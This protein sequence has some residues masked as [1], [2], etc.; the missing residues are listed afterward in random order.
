MN[1]ASR[2]GDHP[3]EKASRPKTIAGSDN[4]LPT[5]SLV[6]LLLLS[7]LVIVIYSNTFSASFHF[8][9]EQNIVTNPQ[10]KGLSNFLDFSASRYV[11]FLSFAL[12][13]H[14]GRLDVFG[15]HLVNLLIHITNGLLVYTLVL[16]VFK[17][18]LM[19]PSSAALLEPSAGGIAQPSAWI[20]FITALLFLVHPLQ[21]QAVTYIVQRFTSLAT[22]FYLLSI[23]CYLK[24]RLAGP[25]SKGRTAWYAGAFVSTLLAMKTKEISFTL[26][27]MILWVEAIFFWPLTRKQW[28]ALIPFLLTLPIIPLSSLATLGE[29]EGGFAR[30]TTDIGRLDYLFTQFRVIVTYLRLLVLPIGQNLDYDYPIYHSLLE[31]AVLL[32]FFFL[33]LLVGLAV[34]LVFF[35][36]HRLLAFG[37]LWFFLTLS[38]E[39]SII[40]IR[41]VIFEHR[42]YLPSVGLILA[43]SAGVVEGLHRWRMAVSIGV[44]VVVVLFSVATYQRN[45]VWNDEVSLWADV[46]Q[47]SPNKARGYINLGAVCVN[48]NRLE[49]AVKAYKAAIT[50]LTFKPDLAHANLNLALSYNNLGY[51]YNKL[52][53]L[54]EAIQAYK[55]A[56]KFNPDYA[57]AHNNLGNT[58]KKLERLDEAIQEYKTASTLVPDLVDAHYNLGVVYYEQGR[59]SEA[60][61]AF[62]E[63]VQLKPDFVLA[64]NKLGNAYK[65]LE[66]LDEAIQEYKTALTLR[67]DLAQVHYNLGLIY[68]EQGKLPEAITVFQGVLQ[69]Q[70]D[71]ASAHNSLGIVYEDLGRWEDAIREYQISLKQNPDLVEIHYNLGNVYHRAGRIQEAIFEF[72][73][74]LQI[75]PDYEKA[76]QA[77]KVLP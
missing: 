75:K 45:R 46:V 34:Y 42:L 66:R 19:G 22:L 49:E 7:L 23:V 12:N 43:A 44:A 28:G 15:Y 11:G 31:P 40:P 62:K 61:V 21:T 64:H 29:A 30:E 71:F 69:L 10:I 26:P 39:S 77:L 48:Q 2:K 59:L 16:L 68:Y 55:T 9:D 14:F 52:E 51:I 56:L 67:P 57:L 47:K 27:F 65:K 24:W 33:S 1:K 20:A 74:A 76:R 3:V 18:P 58:Y 73:Q 54:D 32:S 38:I 41:D 36:Q 72:Q 6:V 25:D 4:G 50:L 63:A 53:N 8:D 17:T 35:S 37:L 70:P 13:Y 5:Q 60:I